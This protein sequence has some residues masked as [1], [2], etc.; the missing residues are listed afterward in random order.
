MNRSSCFLKLSV[1]SCNLPP[2]RFSFCLDIFT[3]Q[4]Q[5]LCSFL[6]LEAIKILDFGEPAETMAS[7]QIC[8]L[9]VAI[10]AILQQGGFYPKAAMV[11]VLLRE[12]ESIESVLKRFK[13]E[14]IN[15]GIQSETR[16]REYYE[17]PS[18][19]RKRKREAAV[20]RRAKRR[21]L[22]RRRG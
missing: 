3:V 18:E 2:L 9:F 12:G 10:F 16:R 6:A 15:A 19:T 4:I 11:S 21:L 1:E 13:R 7:R 14:C 5:F 8:S 20:R 17:K 22:L